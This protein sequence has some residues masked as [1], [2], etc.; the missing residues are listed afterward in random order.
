MSVI[1]NNERDTGTV[2]RCPSCSGKDLT[3]GSLQS[4][5]AVHFRP[6]GA[7]FFSFYTAEVKIQAQ[8]CG[9]CGVITMIGDTRRLRALQN[10]KGPGADDP[11]ES[12]HTQDL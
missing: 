4:T 1:E 2:T 3:R 5:G 12:A 11:C 9:V 8:M 10:P 6:Q 7:K